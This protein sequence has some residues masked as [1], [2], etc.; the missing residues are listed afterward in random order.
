[1]SCIV[2][3]RKYLKDEMTS[4]DEKVRNGMK[5]TANGT[6]VV[7]LLKKVT[8]A[9]NITKEST[10]NSL[11]ELTGKEDDVLY[12]AAR[13]Q[14]KEVFKGSFTKSNVVNKNV[15]TDLRLVDVN[16]VKDQYVVKV[17]PA[18][19]D[20]VWTYTFQRGSNVSNMSSN[21]NRLYVPKIDVVFKRAEDTLKDVVYNVDRDAVIEEGRQKIQDVRDYLSGKKKTLGSGKKGVGTKG[22]LKP[23]YVHG[24]IDSMKSMLEELQV[25][26]NNPASV[27]HMKHLRSLFDSMAPHFFRDMSLFINDNTSDT[28]GWVDLNDSSVNINMGKKKKKFGKSEAEVYAHEVIHTM[29]HWALSNSGYQSNKLKRELNYSFK[30]MMD[31]TTWEDLLG[32]PVGEAKKYEIKAAKDMY[33]YMFNSEN[34]NDEFIAHVLTN[35]NVMKH[36]KSVVLKR[37]NEKADTLFGK[38]MDIMYAI[39]DLLLGNYNFNTKNKSVYE[40]VHSLSF[41][42]AEINTKAED[43]LNELNVIE[44]FNNM[45]SNAEVDIHDK[46]Q[47]YVD[48]HKKDFSEYKDLPANATSFEKAMYVMKFFGKALVDDHWRDA[49]GNYFSMLG[50][51]PEGSIREI[52]GSLYDTTGV[53][54]AV[55]WAGLKNANIDTLRSTIITQSKS[56]I[57]KGFSRKLSSEEDVAITTAMLDTNLSTLLYKGQV[58]KKVFTYEEI[59]DMLKSEATLD[60]EIKKS[61]AKLKATIKALGESSETNWIMKQASGLGYFMATHRGHQV[62]LTNAE[63]IAIG[64]LSRKRRKLDKNLV[65]AINEVASLVA[66]KYT[67]KKSKTTLAE[68]VD[69]EA[70]GIDNVAG[71]YEAFKKESESTLFNG[72]KAHVMAGYTKQI[73]DE[74]TDIK[75]VPMSEREEMESMG[76]QFISE[77]KPSGGEVRTVKLG[78]FVSDQYGK[79]ERLRGAVNLGNNKA[80]GI[81]IKEIK[82]IES[83]EHGG[84]RFGNDMKRINAESSKLIDDMYNST[85]MDFDTMDMGLMPVLNAHGKVVDYR[86]M[87]VDK[88]AKAERMRQTLEATEVLSRSFGSLVDKQMREDHNKDVLVLVKELM[89][90]DL[91][92][93][94]D[95]GGETGIQEYRRI[96]P[97]VEDQKMKELFYMLPKS[98]QEYAMSREDKVIAVPAELVRP[99]F[100]YKHAQIGD[101]IPKGVVPNTV[102]TVIQ[103]VLNMVEAYW[104]DLVKIAKGNILLKMPMV[105]VGNVVSNILYMVNTGMGPTELWNYH[106]E[107]FRDV[108]AFMKAH[109]EVTQ[110]DL[111]IKSSREK[112]SKAS[113]V[114]AVKREIQKNTN[115]L[116]RLRKEMQSSPINELVEAGLYQSVVEDVETAQLNDTNKVSNALDKLVSK[117]PMVVRKGAQW[118]YLSKETAWYQFNQEVLQLSDLIARDVMNRKQKRV[119]KLMADGKMT[120]PKEMRDA[121]G[122]VQ[123]G[124]VLKGAVREKFFELSKNARMNNLLD[125]FINYV[126]P[127]GKWE[128]WMN[129]IGL[130]MFTK[131]LKRIQRVIVTAGSRHPIRTSIML[132]GALL[133]VNVDTIQA[134]SY[135]S[136]SFDFNHDFSIMHILPMYNFGETF[137]NVVTPAI[138]KDEVPTGLLF[139]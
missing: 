36:A 32:K 117:A 100:G 78:M 55:E 109:K 131:Y 42:L 134:Q 114:N 9:Y 102:R 33:E 69:T 24:D 46:V 108:K 67:D 89:S 92:D 23:E 87:A 44:K 64:Y 126:K 75:Y 135:I 8:H 52:V 45:V 95:L 7:N 20:D 81:S 133:G 18:K 101:L 71:M 35:P 121:L 65:A 25:K 99:L 77:V 130:L 4:L 83:P 82:Y 128:E 43:E 53:A 15:A 119:E 103:R 96:G 12:V 73:F 49:A 124:R 58:A 105:L 34:A 22:V 5:F 30:K 118:A 85:P 93:G 76:Y 70:K 123:K 19:K 56:Q 127:N 47:E 90:D 66:L 3:F 61:R 38:I 106:K 2:D 62:Q 60:K 112:L 136:K 10:V 111:K 72:D 139:A 29:T 132:A 39:A 41:K 1:M 57:Q 6:D 21:G 84:L 68:L 54:R 129:R 86:Y 74:T 113:D 37:D 98:F 16:V 88:K 11:E 14:L 63:N 110:L 116:N 91:W 94:G 17:S 13:A 138:V 79:A 27:E 107:S 80:K 48:K 120:M 50:I 115:R 59:S 104:M 122:G 125:V 97:D 26:G 40:Q 51:K 31:K 137:M 28:M